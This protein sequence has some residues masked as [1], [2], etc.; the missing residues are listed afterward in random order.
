[1]TFFAGRCASFVVLPL[2][3]ASCAGWSPRTASNA[4][5]SEFGD[6]T[7]PAEVQAS[8]PPRSPAA[9]PAM[10]VMGSIVPTRLEVRDGVFAVPGSEPKLQRLRYV[11]GQVSANDSCVIRLSNRLN[12]KIPPLYVNGQPLGFC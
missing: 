6:R 9:A 10:R 11:D 12:P 4:P 3:L 5:E 1:M 7:A 2:V 8:E